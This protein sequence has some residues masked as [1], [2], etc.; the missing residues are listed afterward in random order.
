[1]KFMPYAFSIGL[2]LIGVGCPPNQP[3]L[4]EFLAQPEL[5]EI[6]MTV[7]FWNY[8][9]PGGQQIASWSWDFGDGG[10]SNEENPVHVYEAVNQYT[11]SLTVNTAAGSDTVVKEKCIRAVADG[12]ASFSV[13]IENTGA[14]PVVGLFVALSDAG[15][16]GGSLLTAPL[17]PGET[18]TPDALFEPGV[19]IVCVSF[20]VG[21]EYEGAAIQG[22]L[23]ARAGDNNLVH[24][25][26]FRR[27]NGEKGLLAEWAK[28]R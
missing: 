16:I 1:M 4:A 11:V 7:Q 21:E 5:G 23:D 28:G 14:Y 17:L 10:K 3:P 19:Y 22:N 26:A 24:L 12:E 8:S 6:P 20:Q 13:T 9:L 15:T 18:A 27:D 25:E 2:L